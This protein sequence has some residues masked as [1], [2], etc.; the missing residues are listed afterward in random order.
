MQQWHT[1]K[2]NKL[3]QLIKLNKYETDRLQQYSRRESIRINGI[4]DGVGDSE[5]DIVDFITEVGNK[6]DVPLKR[7][8]I[9]VAHHVGKSQH[10]SRPVLAK[11][12]SRNTRDKLVKNRKKLKDLTEHTIYIND[13]LTPLRAKLFSYGK[14]LEN[15]KRVS[16]HNGVIHCNTTRDDHIVIE[17][18]DDLFK[19]GV[20]KTPYDHLGLPDFNDPIDEDL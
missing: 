8:D 5:D 2:L 12:I 10:G 18:P 19:L 15:V 6:I 20:D 4:C 13:D 1:V 14:K 9:S 11:F 16:T 3:N 7:D 17:T